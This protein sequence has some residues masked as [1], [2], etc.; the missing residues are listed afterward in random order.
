MR[1]WLRTMFA[2]VLSLIEDHPRLCTGNRL[3]QTEKQQ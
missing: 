1:L 3:S 2:A